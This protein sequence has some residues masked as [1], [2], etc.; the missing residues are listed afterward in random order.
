M[1]TC[2]VPSSG[3]TWPV[4]RTFDTNSLSSPWYF[5]NGV[6]RG[7]PRFCKD[8]NTAAGE[9]LLSPRHNDYNMWS[10]ASWPL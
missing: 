2:I 1:A 9:A 4:H 5:E 7:T 6:P 10:K 3:A 8:C